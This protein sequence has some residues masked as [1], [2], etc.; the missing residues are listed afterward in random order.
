MDITADLLKKNDSG[1]VKVYAQL[2]ADGAVD[3]VAF[4]P[5]GR[6]FVTRNGENTLKLWDTANLRLLGTLIGNSNRVFAFSPA[7]RCV[8]AGNDDDII[9]LWDLASGQVILTLSER[10]HGVDAVAFSQDGGSC[11]VLGHYGK[12]YKLWDAE[13]G[14]ELSTIGG[15]DGY[16]F[17]VPFS[18]DG[19]LALSKS[20]NNIKLW[21]IDS[22]KLIRTLSGHSD[23]VRE[24]AFSPD[25]RSAISC[26][27]DKTIK[28]WD[29]ASGQEIRSLSGHTE[30][31]TAVAFSPDGRCIVSGCSDS[32]LKLWEI[33]SGQ[34]LLSW[35]GHGSSEVTSVA[36][37]SDGLSIVSSDEYGGLKFW[38]MVTGIEQR[39]LSK[40]SVGVSAI[41]FSPDGRIVVSAES[42][43]IKL[44]DVTSGRVVHTLI[45]HT[46]SVN[47]FAFFPD[48]RSVVSGSDDGTIKLWDIDSGQEIR[49]FSGHR[50]RVNVVGFSPD[51][52]S[53]V[54]GA[55]DGTI[56][57]W[58]IDSGKE[59]R[60]FVVGG[61]EISAVAFSP[62]GG[63]V[64]S[65]SRNS[66]NG[67]AYLKF[68]D[69]IN[70]LK[71]H[72]LE[73]RSNRLI[74]VAFSEDGSSILSVDDSFSLK[75]WD[76]A[77]GQEIRKLFG[78]KYDVT[79]AAFSPDGL[80]VASIRMYSRKLKLWNMD[81]EEELQTLRVSGYGGA[82]F[83]PD[84]QSVISCSVD[85][86]L[87]MWNVATGKE[88]AQFISFN[89]GEWVTI[90]PEG[91]YVASE[92]GDQ[93]L[94]VRDG[95]EVHDVYRIDKYRETFHR[96]D[97]VRNALLGSLGI[98][99]LIDQAECYYTLKAY[100]QSLNM[101]KKAMVSV[102][103]NYA[104]VDSYAHCQKILDLSGKDIDGI[105]SDIESRQYYRAPID[106]VKATLDLLLQR[107][108]SV[109]KIPL[110][111][112]LEAIRTI[113]KVT[114]E[115][116]TSIVYAIQKEEVQPE[117]SLEEE[118]L[119]EN[120]SIECLGDEL[121]Q[122]AENIETP[123]M[124]V[125]EPSIISANQL[126]VHEAGKVKVYAQLWH[127]STVNAVAL[128][129]DGRSCVTGSSDHTLKLWDAISLQLLGTLRG[130][131]RGVNSVAFSPDSRFVVSCSDDETI[132]L[133]D[134]ASRQ[135]I[136]TFSGHKR[137]V[138][139]VAY[140]PD[141]RSLVSGSEDC[142]LKQWDVV[143]GRCL[144]TISGNNYVNSVVYSPDGQR[145]VSANGDTL[146]IWDVASGKKLQT[147]SG[148]GLYVSSVAFSPD[149]RSIVS[150][151]SDQTLLLWNVESGK[152]IRTLSGHLDP[153]TA[154]AFSPD[155]HSIVSGC[156][157]NSIK[158]WDA[159]SGR[160]LLSWNGHSGEGIKTVAYSSDG[161][162]IISC[163]EYDG[164]K[165]WD[166][167]TGKELRTLGNTSDNVYENAF[168]PDG[169][170]IISGGENGNLKLWDVTSGQVIR[171]LNGHEREVLT[172]A[173]SPDG[174][175]VASGGYDLITKL[176]DVESGR[177]LH[178]LSGHTNVVNS[179][180]FTPDGRSIVS[181]SGDD[182]LKLW[183]VVTGG[184]LCTLSAHSYVN[185]VAISPDGRIVVSGNSN[186]CITL[187]DVASGK[188]IHT[189]S[190]HE[191]DVRAVAFS[192]DGC[193]VVSGSWDGSLKLW[194]V[195][196]GRILRTLKGHERIV[197]AVAFSPNGLTIV[198]SGWDQTFRL[199]D[200]ASG[201]ELNTLSG[202]CIYGS[203]VAFS[204]DGL[205]IISGSLDRTIKMWNVATGK[206][207]AQFISFK[208][209]EWVT[210]TPEGYYEA[211]EL[212]DQHLNV[213]DGIELHDVYRIDK[214]R[215]TFHRPD[216]VKA[217]LS[218]YLT[219][220]SL[221]EQAECYYALQA[222]MQS[223]NMLKKAVVRLETHY[224]DIESSVHCQKILD[225][226]E[227]MINK[228]FFDINNRQNFQAQIDI[229][230]ASLDLLQ[231]E[232][233]ADK[234]PHVE[235]LESIRKIIKIIEEIIS[236]VSPE[237]EKP[238]EQ[239]DIDTHGDAPLD[240]A[241]IERSNILCDEGGALFSAGKFREAL[242]LYQQDFI[243]CKDAFGETHS[244][245]V[246][247]ILDQAFCYFVLVEFEQALDM[248]KR[249]ML[250]AETYSEDD[251]AISQGRRVLDLCENI[252]ELVAIDVE[253]MLNY[254]A[255]IQLILHVLRREEQKRKGSPETTDQNEYIEVFSRIQ[256][257]ISA[258]RGACAFGIQKGAETAVETQTKSTVESQQILADDW[259]A[260]FSGLS[261]KDTHETNNE[262]PT[263]ATEKSEEISADDWGAA[264]SR[265]SSKD[266]HVTNNETLTKAAEES[267]EISADDWGAA[268]SEMAA[269][270]TPSEDTR[271]DRF[272]INGGE[273][274]DTE[275]NLTW[276]RCSVGLH[277]EEGV[278]CVGEA[279][280]LFSF[281]EAQL[282][283]YGDWRLPDKDELASLIVN[284]KSSPMI[285]QDAF[286]DMSDDYL[287]YWSSTTVENNASFGWLVY[288]DN[289]AVFNYGRSNT[290]AVRL[291]RSGKCFL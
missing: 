11:I 72:T 220:N 19:R 174:R 205:N 256:A 148:H 100:K 281:D 249:A 267:E 179:V 113:I 289:G 222:Y 173:F 211:S 99:S 207:I 90:T 66:I 7:G 214:Y 277:W 198:S 69:V 14:R 55:D 271:N 183:D 233:S 73:E 231:R 291:V 4:S 17:A 157:D 206:E 221:I 134:I 97:L 38:D 274:Y 186:K 242:E 175:Y 181:G 194:D 227:K 237:E 59:I 247:S 208:D 146:S 114:N 12:T 48:G 195:A 164:L 132:K 10:Y 236:S 269:I 262:T 168:S 32:V 193:C 102:E 119:I 210:I 226:S 26:S 109:A 160:E 280:N 170:T 140:S 230:K 190:G 22:G 124:F 13:S 136:R 3:A 37:S 86:T 172:V 149:G 56:K 253:F 145:I 250:I 89:D 151:S 16:F 144:R 117:S 129:P 264:M 116:S 70:G 275:T 81:S 1:Q 79:T 200:V 34:E 62:D 8:V 286:P 53:L 184:E 192:P 272:I 122:Q 96:P 93:H 261:S 257:V 217:A 115:I 166:G 223:F 9:K 213:R 137:N 47:S 153:V 64:V 107:E 224:A 21:D 238:I 31:V 150:A 133:W 225:L 108:K 139:A 104:E 28:L 204:P 167:T 147:F 244:Y 212:G 118:N 258:L 191:G 243:V 189:L 245:V 252:R 234:I 288:F 165:F 106:V 197:E 23:H 152:V 111:E 44:W 180:A 85:R 46:S 41:A 163:G 248:C 15:V 45:G 270:D 82:A 120:S 255:E 105:F 265:L 254:F 42:K 103:N 87:K 202:N 95:N 263:K 241:A 284:V 6:S 246:N 155:G 185:S 177:E 33:T 188:E 279:K 278:G 57:L 219:I 156:F 74:A 75:I 77:S 158:L 51:Y 24:A 201:M 268:M 68:W 199:W 30:Y 182:S 131:K 92:H 49:T 40:T 143:S 128:S 52:R 159:A 88:I 283:S 216:L 239:A 126:K 162:S 228:I 94:N 25:G 285:N 71:I 125:E 287:F 112:I 171:M 203:D 240:N 84:G 251:S 282:Q 154:V 130:H 58:K 142:T 83:S 2:W 215:E 141:G 27:H 91:Y 110:G 61:D 135:E 5:D 259:G 80:T 76:V 178:T 123:A 232:H 266:S 54:S 98:N 101:L 43:T 187:W 260:A 161:L 196:R 65:A 29:V 63:Y 121:V 209:G 169:R 138:R 35:N 229:E 78:H 127:S 39:N 50:G 60:T 290:L 218:E 18:P 36:F 235:I 176:W 67:Y 273:V 20:G 276:Q